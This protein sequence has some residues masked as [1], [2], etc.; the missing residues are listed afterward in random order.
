MIC[1]VT[2]LPCK[3]NLKKADHACSPLSAATSPVLS[4]MFLYPSSTA[5]CFCSDALAC[6]SFIFSYETVQRA[7][8]MRITPTAVDHDGIS[9]NMTISRMYPHKMSLLLAIEPNPAGANLPAKFNINWPIEPIEHMQK[10]Y[11]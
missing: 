9:S 6:S 1:S 5:D 4:S 8:K 2:Y 3:Q 10:R 7:I 11:Q